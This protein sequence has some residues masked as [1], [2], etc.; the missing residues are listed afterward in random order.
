MVVFDSEAGM[1]KKAVRHDIG[2]ELL[3]TF[4]AVVD[5]RSFKIAA[6]TLRISQPTVSG[7]IARLQQHLG[8]PLFDKSRPGVWLT[9]AGE[10]AA[11]SA[12]Q[13]LS[14]HDDIPQRIAAHAMPPSA[15]AEFKIGC[16]DELRCWL[17][18]PAL[19]EFQKQHRDIRFVLRRGTSEQLMDQIRNG[20]L[21]LSATITRERSPNAVQSWK[22][23][24]F[25]AGHPETTIDD[26]GPLPIVAPPDGLIK[27]AMLAEL[28]RQKTLFTIKFQA[29][30]MDGAIAAAREGLGITVVFGT[31]IPAGLVRISDNDR[32]GALPPIYWGLYEKPVS[33]NP[34]MQQLMDQLASL[35][36][37]TIQSMDRVSSAT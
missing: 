7:H 37:L 23:P 8:V 33:D 2:V 31:G 17:L 30:H 13:I 5:A 9:R 25:W 24:L 16:P 34:T 26:E 20:E 3:R 35:L 22:Q 14:V 4:L 32:L 18:V 12:R 15:T 21:D 6:A 10:I 1:G 27:D 28:T 19:A 36:Q 11:D 29:A